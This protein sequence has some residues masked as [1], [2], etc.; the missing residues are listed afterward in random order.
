MGKVDRGL[1]GRLELHKH[2]PF[3]LAWCNMKTRCDNP[4]STQ[5]QWYGGRGISY[6]EEWGTFLNFYKDMFP[7]WESGLML[8]RVDNNEGYSKGNCRW[9]TARE[10]ALNRRSTR[11]TQD[12]ANSIRE[13]YKTGR[14]T[15]GNL[16]ERFGVSQPYISDILT[17]RAW[18]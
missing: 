5:H 10:N 12:I 16:A 3:Y 4:N 6:C 8:D 14:Y 15:Q 13:L 18:K 1:L 11:I 2:H 17:H 9:V 7:E